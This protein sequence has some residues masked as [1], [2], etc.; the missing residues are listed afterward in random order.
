MAPGRDGRRPRRTWPQRLLITFN[1]AMV[2]ATLGLAAALGYANDKLEQVQHLDLG[3]GVLDPAAEDPGEPQNYLLVGTDSAARLDESDPA[4][5]ADEGVLSDTIMVLRVDPDETQAQL[6]SFPR[7]LWVNIP[8]WGESK[9]NAALSAGRDSLIATIQENFGIPINHYVE[10]DFL[11]FQELVEAVDGVPVYFDKPLRD[12]HTGLNVTSTGCVTL[13]PDQALA[14]A[15]SRYLQYYEDGGW[16]YDGTGDFGRISR[17]QDFIRRTI[18][19][20]IDKGVRNPLTLNTLINA[21]ISSVSLDD[22][23]VVDDLLQLGRRFRSFDP[24]QL[25]TMALDVYLDSVGE[26]SIVRMVDNEANQARL[27]IF[28]GVAGPDAGAGAADA[29][30]VGITTLNGTGTGGQA[31][32]VAA[33][34]ANLGFDTSPG[35]DDAERFDFAQTVIR[36]KAGD[37]ANAQFV[38]SQ[39][40]AGAQLEQVADTGLANVQV[41]TGLDFAGVKPTLV[42]PTTAAPS[43]STPS[44]TTTLPDLPTTTVLGEVP[45]APEGESC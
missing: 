33:A 18:Q 2:M 22:T 6:L 26:I 24:E 45:Q 19:R 7:D 30:S 13:S 25:R 38:A 11:G 27:N 20:A 14:Y 15:R 37:E 4:A 31:T 44:P 5:R 1:I 16:Y 39:L 43:P 10:V 8:D 42:P 12:T 32:E 41:I 35:I 40:V 36:Y 29:A 21:G 9:I 23:L 34:F 3:T 28:R 17:Q